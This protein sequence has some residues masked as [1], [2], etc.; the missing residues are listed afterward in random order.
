M[1]CTMEKPQYPKKEIGDGGH[2]Q[3]GG[4]EPPD[5]AVVS[6][7]AVHE[8]PERIHEKQ[9]RPDDAELPGREDF[10]VYEGLLDDTQAQPAYVIQAVCNDRTPECLCPESPVDLI[11]HFGRDLILRRLAYPIEIVQTHYFI[12]KGLKFSVRAQR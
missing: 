6:D 5:V 3:P 9:G 1:D 11:C 2:E 7:K 8:F 10:P 12:I 4:H